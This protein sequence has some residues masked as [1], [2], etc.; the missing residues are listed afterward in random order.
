MI[1][2]IIILAIAIFIWWNNSLPFYSEKAKNE[3]ESDESNLIS[4]KAH[5]IVY[6]KGNRKAVLFLHGFPASP[7]LYENAAKMFSEEGYDVF[8]PLIPTFASDMEKFT[9]TN[10]TE[11]YDFIAKKYEE[12]ERKYEEV[13]VIGVSMGG[14]MTLKIAE[15]YR[16]SGI[17]VIAAPVTYNSFLRDGIISDWHFYIARFLGLFTKSIG[18][19]AVTGRPESHDGDENWI[20]YDG[21]FIHQSISFIYNLK[22]IRKNLRKV[23]SPAI[24]IHDK[25]DRTV[26]F[27][28]QEIIRKGISS[29]KIKVI[30]PD[31]GDE[32]HHSR[33]NLLM[34]DSV[35]KEYTV[36]ILKFFNEV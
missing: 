23:V 33:H 22:T 10:F 30:S 21:A 15:D 1:I 5:S 3:L 7:V 25:G 31:M 17:A 11:W 16:P 14:S 9:E 6:E 36:D 19:K 26:P 4:P 13:Y 27:K 24:L 29:G 32:Y 34:Y 20:G 2:L 8:A 12:L 18:A 35:G 28:N